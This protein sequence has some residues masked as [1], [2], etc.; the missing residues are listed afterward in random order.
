VA[1]SPLISFA[2]IISTVPILRLLSSASVPSS[3]IE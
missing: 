2:D 1:D 3:T